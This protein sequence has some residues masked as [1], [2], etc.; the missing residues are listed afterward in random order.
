MISKT[1]KEKVEKIKAFI[2]KHSM[3]NEEYE[4]LDGVQLLDKLVSN[5]ENAELYFVPEKG[6]KY[7]TAK[8][9]D[10]GWSGSSK[11]LMGG[12]QIA[13]TGDYNDCYCPICES[14]EIEEMH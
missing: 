4:I 14:I 13:D 3:K 8:C 6:N 9:I 2:S 5:L 7:F 10:C 11:F 1:D 12:G